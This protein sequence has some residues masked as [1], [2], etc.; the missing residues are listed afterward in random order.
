MADPEYILVS[1]VDDDAMEANLSVKPISSLES[2]DYLLASDVSD[3]AYVGDLTILPYD[4]I[5]DSGVPTH[6]IGSTVS[7]NAYEDDLRI[8]ELSGACVATVDHTDKFF[9]VGNTLYISADTYIKDFSCFKLTFTGTT[10]CVIRWG[11]TTT[12][13][14][15]TI[16]GGVAVDNTVVGSGNDK[17]IFKFTLGISAS[18]V[19]KIE[20]SDDVDYSYEG[21]GGD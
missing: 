11:D 7:D 4:S 10:T 2:G 12:T 13:D 15:G 20:F 21:G 14:Y 1:D 5:S 9:D 8:I 17:S 18:Q 3:N 16:T 19:T 6:F